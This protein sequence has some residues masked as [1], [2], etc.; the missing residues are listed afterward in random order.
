M[1]LHVTFKIILCL[2]IYRN[3]AVMQSHYKNS[4]EKHR[5]EFNNVLARMF[6]AIKAS[7]ISI[8]GNVWISSFSTGFKRTEAFAHCTFIT[9]QV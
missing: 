7:S 6:I 4:F 3:F 2:N 1:G 5:H 8:I 9:P